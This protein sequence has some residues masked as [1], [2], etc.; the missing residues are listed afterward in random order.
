MR[1][2]DEIERQKADDIRRAFRRHWQAEE[3]RLADENTRLAR[4]VDAAR[5]QLAKG[6]ERR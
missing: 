1:T 6:K 5:R 2:R 3:R 4:A